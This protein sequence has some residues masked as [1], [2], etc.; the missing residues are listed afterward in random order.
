MNALQKKLKS[1]CSLEEFLSD[2]YEQVENDSDK[3]GHKLDTFWFAEACRYDNLKVAQWLYKNSGYRLKLNGYPDVESYNAFAAAIMHSSIDTLRW[4]LTLDELDINV[5]HNKKF[6]NLYHTIDCDFPKDIVIKLLERGSRSYPNE[7]LLFREVGYNSFYKSHD[8]NSHVVSLLLLRG[9]NS[10]EKDGLKRTVYENAF[11]ILRSLSTFS[12][13]RHGEQA[14]NYRQICFVLANW[15]MFMYVYCFGFV[16]V[17]VDVESLILLY[18][19]CQLDYEHLCK[20]R[21]A[22]NAE[23]RKLEE[24]FDDGTNEDDYYDDDYYEPDY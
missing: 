17:T 3:L 20:E 12:S 11:D 6:S 16:G 13:K 7:E 4:L 5:Q 22:Y 24:S 8:G 19:I 18:Q 9:A 10:C 1:L 2:F 23:K 15:H 14:K 21:Y